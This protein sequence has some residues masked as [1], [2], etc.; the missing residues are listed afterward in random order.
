MNRNEAMMLTTNEMTMCEIDDLI[1]KIYDDF[2]KEKEKNVCETCRWFIV[3][4][5]SCTN[6]L[7]ADWLKIDKD[8]SCD[9]W[10]IR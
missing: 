7:I 9:N 8:D 6:P 2:E 4:T 10:E 3:G 1:D 5:K